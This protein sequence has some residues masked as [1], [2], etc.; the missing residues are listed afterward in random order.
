MKAV[1]FHVHGDPSVLLYED[2]PDPIARPG[3]AIVR[4]RACALNHLDLFQRHGL[5]RVS[6]P[7]PY[8][9][10]DIAGEVVDRATPARL[11]VSG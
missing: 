1:R 7:A 11:R 9:R 4:V 8:F 10:A 6:I 2:A 3:W 5:E